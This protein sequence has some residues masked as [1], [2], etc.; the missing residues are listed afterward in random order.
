[1]DLDLSARRPCWITAASMRSLSSARS[2][3]FSSIESDT[4]GR[5]RERAR[6]SARE[7]GSERGSE[8][9]RAR[10]RERERAEE[11]EGARA[12]SNAVSVASPA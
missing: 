3:I 10:A 4:C 5:E 2:I 1:M 6:A 7:R 9:E 12:T 8:R 11:R